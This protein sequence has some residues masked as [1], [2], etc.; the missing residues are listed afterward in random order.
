MYKYKILHYVSFQLVKRCPSSHDMWK[1]ESVMSDH[2]LC[3]PDWLLCCWI[4]WFIVTILFSYYMRSP[5]RIIRHRLKKTEEVK[6]SSTPLCN[7]K[8]KFYF[9]NL[10][11]MFYCLSSKYFFLFIFSSM[12][13]KCSHHFC[14]INVP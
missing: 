4:C 6:S 5:R 1:W 2:L 7:F 12:F 10:T 13:R 14:F 8:E 9:E 11:G 3:T